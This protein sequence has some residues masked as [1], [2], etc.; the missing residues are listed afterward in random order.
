MKGVNWV[1]VAI[2]T[3]V[4]WLIGYLWYGM[5][6]AEAWMAAMN[7]TKESMDQSDMTPMILGFVNT[8]VT[9]VGLGL[10]VP[11]VEDGL[12]GGLKTGLMAG[13]FFACTTEAM[14]FIY[15]G[16][17]QALIPIDFGYLLVLYAVAG[18]IIGGVKLGKKA[19]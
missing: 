1:G 7:M 12:M 8:L 17:S 15:G 10:I 14:G 2:A 18:A 16:K 5:L 9:C 6:F 4:V 11:K 13:V 19:A 3:I